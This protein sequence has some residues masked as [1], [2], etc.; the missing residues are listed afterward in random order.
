MKISFAKVKLITLLGISLMTAGFGVYSA[1]QGKAM[2]K[3][4]DEQSTILLEKMESGQTADLRLD[5]SIQTETLDFYQQPEEN[6]VVTVEMNAVQHSEF[7]E[8]AEK[9]SQGEVSGIGVLKIDKIDLKMPVTYG[10]GSHQLKV[11]AGWVPETASIGSYGNAVIA[12]HRNY[13]KGS[14]FNRLGEMAV[15][16]VIGYTPLDGKEMRFVVTEI[17][18]ALPGDSVAFEQTTDVQMLTLYT[19]TPVRTATHRLLVRATRVS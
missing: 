17:L 4:L 6:D 2:Q 11:A 13:T 9:T 3:K 14:H 16:D 10:A 7:K 18:E 5:E 12:G 19:C 15:G 1:L 8:A